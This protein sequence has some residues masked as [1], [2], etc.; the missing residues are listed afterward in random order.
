MTHLL[1]KHAQLYLNLNLLFINNVFV[2]FYDISDTT[3]M[4]QF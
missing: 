1:N 3:V 2:I 4:T